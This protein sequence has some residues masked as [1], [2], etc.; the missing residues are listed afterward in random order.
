M[1]ISN[2]WMQILTYMVHVPP[3]KKHESI[4]HMLTWDQQQWCVVRTE[5]EQMY[6]GD[7]MTNLEEEEEEK[8][9]RF[10]WEQQLWG[11]E[12]ANLE[13]G[14]TNSKEDDSKSEGGGGGWSQLIHTDTAKEYWLYHN[15][16]WKSKS[17]AIFVSEPL[18]RKELLVDWKYFSFKNTQ[19]HC[20]CRCQYDT[21]KGK[22]RG[23]LMC[24]A[25]REYPSL[26]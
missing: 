11:G 22:T 17:I 13:E 20:I 23:S 14:E 26:L 9:L 12:I 16:F 18:L 25:S 15:R 8:I 6:H 19:H 4:Y 21:R 5:V 7:E 24:A 2:N 1:W 10:W 3:L